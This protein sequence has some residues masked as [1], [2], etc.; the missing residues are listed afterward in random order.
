MEVA[1]ATAEDEEDRDRRTTPPARQRHRLPGSADRPAHGEYHA[2]HRAPHRAQ[3]GRALPAR[4]LEDGRQAAPPAL[5]PAALRSA[6]VPSDRRQPW[7]APL[8]PFA[9][10]A[11]RG[12]GVLPFPSRISPP[13]QSI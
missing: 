3:E 2:A 10:P 5:V 1:S 13:F 6:P 12:G 11:P 7:P 9:R 4:A 8:A